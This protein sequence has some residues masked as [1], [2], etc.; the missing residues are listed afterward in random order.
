MNT[1]KLIIIDDEEG[2]LSL[3]SELA[4]EIGYKVKTYTNALDFVKEKNLKAD[5]IIL[6]MMMPDMDGIEVIMYLKKIA[7]TSK[8]IL[9][10][11]HP[12]GLFEVA[13]QLAKMEGLDVIEN[14][15]KPFRMAELK[16]RL[17]SLYLS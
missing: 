9:M 7:C 10:S 15:I 14:L 11:G 12:G 2:L 16:K 5:L 13:Q 3:I 1:K 8:I 6:D 17:E 4:C